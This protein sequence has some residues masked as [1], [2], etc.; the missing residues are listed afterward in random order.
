MK[1]LR[2]LFSRS[3]LSRSLCWLALMQCS[4]AQAGNLSAP[5]LNSREN[6]DAL[7]AQRLPARAHHV[8]ILPPRSVHA[9]ATL[10]QAPKRGK[11]GYMQEMLGFRQIRTTA[12]VNHTVQ[13]RSNDGALLIAYVDER[14]AARMQKTLSAGEP[15]FFSM[16]LLWQSR[17]G[18]GL[19]I[20]DFTPL[21]HWQRLQRW[22][23]KLMPEKPE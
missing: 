17:H 4:A 12:A 21:S 5:N 6:L 23:R 20:T 7:Y 15:V 22:W 16:T 11:T 13:L 8:Q 2:S 9:E 1:N 3:L 10:V 19:L 14:T 18:P